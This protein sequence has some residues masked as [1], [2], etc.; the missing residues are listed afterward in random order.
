VIDDRQTALGGTLSTVPEEKD[1][2]AWRKA[3]E[4]ALDLDE[5]TIRCP[6]NDDADLKL[7]W[8]EAEE[9]GRQAGRLYCPACGESV[10]IELS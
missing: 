7:E 5:P 6:S 2:A 9:N 4:L 3:V 10:L 8:E 1:Y